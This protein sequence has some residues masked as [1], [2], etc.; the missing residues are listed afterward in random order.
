M[1]T[2]LQGAVYRGIYGSANL[3]SVIDV[4]CQTGNCTWPVF[5]SLGACSNCHDVTADSIVIDN[6]NSVEVPGGLTLEFMEPGS[7]SES[8]AATFLA[9]NIILPRK[10]TA[11]ILTLALGQLKYDN[12]DFN[13]DLTNYNN[14]RAFYCSLDLCIKR[15]INF[16]VV[17]YAFTPG[18]YNNP[19][20]IFGRGDSA[21]ET[22]SH[23]KHNPW[24]CNS[25]TPSLCSDSRTMHMVSRNYGNSFL[26]RQMM[27]IGSTALKL[28]HHSI[29]ALSVR[30]ILI[31][32]TS[33][34]FS[35]KHCIMI[36]SPVSWDQITFLNP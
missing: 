15:Y 12:Q 33:G 9:N 26:Q 30:W 5:T 29:I 28:S 19:S 17:S 2:A 3:T 34:C 18:V 32:P 16:T 25:Q 24:R 14:W 8:G 27:S 10:P 13:F 22:S 1:D 35:T 20:L 36:Y 6:G 7:D 23:T 11:N 4:T 31:S 21:A